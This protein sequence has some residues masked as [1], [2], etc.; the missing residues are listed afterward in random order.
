MIRGY[1]IQLINIGPQHPSTH[2]VLRLI[3]VIALESIQLILPELGLLHRGT[4][5]LIN[6]CSF[7]NLNSAM[8]YF[9]RLD[10]CSSIT[11]ELL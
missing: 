1:N 3:A 9:D 2:G 6:Y 11:Q 10:Y 7:N 4:E 5:K 8:P